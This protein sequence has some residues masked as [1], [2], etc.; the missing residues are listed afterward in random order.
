M[1]RPA[2]GNQTIIL[3]PCKM[4]LQR[5]D[6][7][8]GALAQNGYSRLLSTKV[9][10]GASNRSYLKVSNCFKLAGTP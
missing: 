10:Y 6:E 3:C 9:E 4:L 1:V 7:E 2:T 5:Y 8:K